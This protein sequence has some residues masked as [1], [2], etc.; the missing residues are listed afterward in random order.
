MLT[1][2]VQVDGS[3]LTLNAPGEASKSN[4]DVV[5]VLI[6]DQG[7][8]VSEFEQRLTIDPTRMTKAQQQRLVYSQQ[9]RVTPGLYQVRVAA[10][11]NKTARTGSAIQW[12]EIPDITHGSLSLGS[13]FV[14]EMIAETGSNTG[15]PQQA[16]INVNRLFSR[17]SRLLFQTYIYNAARGASSPDVALQVQVFRDDQPVITAPL[18]KLPTAG[19]VDLTRISYEDDFALDKLPVGSYVLQVTAIDRVAKTSASQRLNFEIQ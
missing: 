19:I 16:L 9:V 15:A 18:R 11:D 14:G 2:S 3:V 4:V 7:K 13:L 8:T 17:T 12:I 10:R 1:A 6:N 5:G